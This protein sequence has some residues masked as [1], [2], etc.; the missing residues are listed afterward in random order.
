M[1]FLYKLWFTLSGDLDTKIRLFRENKQTTI[2]EKV[3]KV[4]KCTFKKFNQEVLSTLEKFGKAQNKRFC[5]Y[6]FAYVH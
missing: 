3:T 6:I 1:G 2:M 4:L 5:A